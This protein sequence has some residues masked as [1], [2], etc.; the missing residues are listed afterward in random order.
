MDL[1]IM[2]MMD[3]IGRARKFWVDDWIYDKPPGLLPRQLACIVAYHPT[4]IASLQTNL[5]LTPTYDRHARP[6]HSLQVQG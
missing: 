1:R 4:T 6:R 5:R 2:I 3:E